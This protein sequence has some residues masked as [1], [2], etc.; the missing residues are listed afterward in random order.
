MNAQ[1][2]I[3]LDFAIGQ[4]GTADRQYSFFFSASGAVIT[5]SW[6]GG[7]DIAQVWGDRQIKRF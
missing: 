5:I 3:N 6:F 7:D 2:K 1:D 4:F